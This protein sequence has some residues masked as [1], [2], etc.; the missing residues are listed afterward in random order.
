MRKRNGSQWRIADRSK[1]GVNKCLIGELMRVVESQTH[2]EIMRML[3]VHQS[4]AIGCF[5][6]LEEQWITA[7]RNRSW[8][9]AEHEVGLETSFWANPMLRGRHEPVRCVKLVPAAW[10]RL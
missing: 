1:V 3:G 10:A 9:E 8:F 7:I 2:D 5:A 4:N 6:G